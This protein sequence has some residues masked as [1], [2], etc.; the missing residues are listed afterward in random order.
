VEYQCRKYCGGDREACLNLLQQGHDSS[1]SG[2]RFDWL[3]EYGP[4]GPSRKVVCET[5][6]EI[7]GLYAVIPKTAHL[8]GQRVLAGRDVD[9]IVARAWRGRGVF[10]A[11]IRWAIDHFTDIDLHFNF[12]NAASEPGFLRNGW[13]GGQA[14]FDSAAQLG[15]R[16][17]LSSQTILYLAGLARRPRTRRL[18]IR[19]LEPRELASLPD[20]HRPRGRDFLVDRS[21]R[22]LSWRYADSPLHEYQIVAR[23]D[24]EDLVDLLVFRGDTDSRRLLLLDVIPYRE[25]GGVVA[26]YLPYL[27][28]RFR[29]WR[30]YAWT[31]M[32][33]EWR[34]GLLR[35]PRARGHTFLMRS[36]D[37]TPVPAA[38]TSLITYGDLEIC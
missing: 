29:G 25:D 5:G 17:V 15:Y 34:R 18:P 8:R 36:R 37:N 11:M 35:S 3:H 1:F 30:V 28:A 6:S 9:P 20:P 7:I 27:E 22:Y 12:A 31:T 38:G 19:S 26:S 33:K 14:L 23:D 16:K 13:R 32:P 24:G 2:R 21:A 10:S 4:A